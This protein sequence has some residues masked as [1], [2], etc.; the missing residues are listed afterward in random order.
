M[1][2]QYKVPGGMADDDCP[3]A[4]LGAKELRS[5]PDRPGPEKVSKHNLTRLPY[6]SWCSTCV[7]AKGKDNHH[8]GSKGTKDREYPQVQI[9][10]LF[11]NSESEFVGEKDAAATCLSMT[12]TT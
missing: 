10:Y 5:P 12:D 4:E 7:M 11:C 6:A 2:D 8:S 9:D 1:E 3:L